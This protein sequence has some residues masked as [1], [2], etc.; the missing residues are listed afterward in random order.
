MIG[1]RGDIGSRYDAASAQFVRGQKMILGS[2]DSN[3][4]QPLN[5]KLF[6]P[7]KNVYP[8]GLRCS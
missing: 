5:V 7:K 2:C 6:E 3:Q 1:D 8:K 4:G